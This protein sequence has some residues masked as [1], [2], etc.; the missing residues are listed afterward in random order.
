MNTMKTLIMLALILLVRSVLSQN[1]KIEDLCQFIADDFTPEVFE[2]Q[3]RAD[4]NKAMKAIFSLSNK[5]LVNQAYG[6]NS[7]VYDKIMDTIRQVSDFNP[8]SVYKKVTNLKILPSNT[9]LKAFGNHTNSVVFYCGFTRH[10]MLCEIFKVASPDPKHEYLWKVLIYNSGDGLEY[11]PEYHVGPRKQYSPVVIYEGPPFLINE[12]WVEAAMNFGWYE[13]VIT[14]FYPRLLGAFDRSNATYNAFIDPKRKRPCAISSY[15]A[16]F[17]FKLNV[18]VCKMIF[19]V[20]S[21][22]GL[23]HFASGSFLDLVSKKYLSKYALFFGFPAILLPFYKLIYQI[24]NM[25]YLKI[26]TRPIFLLQCYLTEVARKFLDSIPFLL[27]ERR[28]K[29]ESFNYE[30]LASYTTTLNEIGKFHFLRWNVDLVDTMFRYLVEI[31]NDVFGTKEHVFFRD[32]KLAYDQFQIARK[33]NIFDAVPTHIAD[34]RGIRAFFSGPDW[35]ISNLGPLDKLS[36]NETFYCELPNFEYQDGGYDRQN[37]SEFSSSILHFLT[38]EIAYQPC[39][40]G[41]EIPLISYLDSLTFRV[42]PMV[43]NCTSSDIEK[44]DFLYTFFSKIWRLLDYKNKLFIYQKAL[45]LVE[46]F[47]AYK[48]IY[49]TYLK[50]SLNSDENKFKVINDRIFEKLSPSFSYSD[51]IDLLERIL[52]KS[53]K[54]ISFLDGDIEITSKLVSILF[55]DSKDLPNPDEMGQFFNV[56]MIKDQIGSASDY[57]YDPEHFKRSLYILTVVSN[58]IRIESSNN[59]AIP[60]NFLLDGHYYNLL[61]LLYKILDINYSP[62]VSGATFRLYFGIPTYF[63][64]SLKVKT[65]DYDITEEIASLSSKEK[66]PLGLMGLD[67]KFSSGFSFLNY[68]QK[69]DAFILSEAGMKILYTFLLRPSTYDNDHTKEALPPVIEYFLSRRDKIL[70]EIFINGDDT[71]LFRLLANYQIILN[72]LMS[73]QKTDLDIGDLEH[74][75]VAQYQPIFAFLKLNTLIVGEKFSNLTNSHALYLSVISNFELIKSFFCKEEIQYVLRIYYDNWRFSSSK[76]RCAAQT[77]KGIQNLVNGNFLIDG[78]TRQL[79]RLPSQNHSLWTAMGIDLNRKYKL[80]FT[81]YKRR[82]DGSIFSILKYN[83]MYFILHKNDAFLVKNGQVEAKYIPQDFKLCHSHLD[84][85]IAFNS[86]MVGSDHNIIAFKRC[87]ESWWMW[88]WMWLWSWLWSEEVF[89]LFDKDGFPYG[90]IYGTNTLVLENS[91][92]FVGNLSSPLPCSFHINSFCSFSS[93]SFFDDFSNREPIFNFVFYSYIFMLKSQAQS[94]YFFD[95]YNGPAKDFYVVKEGGE[96]YFA[97]IKGEKFK[98]HPPAEIKENFLVSSNLPLLFVSIGKSFQIIIPVPLSKPGDSYNF[99]FVSATCK[100]DHFNIEGHDREINLAIAYWLVFLKYYDRAMEY[101]S[102]YSSVS[103]QLTELELVILQNILE[104]KYRDVEYLVIEAWANHFLDEHDIFFKGFL[105]ET[106]RVEKITKIANL[107]SVIPFKYKRVL[108]SFLPNINEHKYLWAYSNKLQI[109]SSIGKPAEFRLD[110][111]SLKKD[112][113]DA[114]YELSQNSFLKIE[115]TDWNILKNIHFPS[116]LS[117]LYKLAGSSNDLTDFVDKLN[118]HYVDFTR[119][120]LEMENDKDGYKIISLFYVIFMVFNKL[121]DKENLVTFFAKFKKNTFPYELLDI[122]DRSVKF[123]SSIPYEGSFNITEILPSSPADYENLLNITMQR[124]A[125][126][127]DLFKANVSFTFFSDAASLEEKLK[128]IVSTDEFL[129][130]FPLGALKDPRLLAQILLCGSVEELGAFFTVSAEKVPKLLDLLWSHFITVFYCES[131]LLKKNT[132]CKAWIEKKHSFPQQAEEIPGQKLLVTMQDKVFILIEFFAKYP[133]REQQRTIMSTILHKIVDEESYAVEQ[134]I[135]GA[136]TMRFG[137][138]IAIMARSVLRKLPIFIFSNSILDQNILQLRQWLFDFFGKSVFEFKTERSDYGYSEPYLRYLYYQLTMAHDRGDVFVSSMNSIQCLLN[139]KKELFSQNTDESKETLAWVLRILHFIEH[140]SM[141]VFD[142][143]DASALYSFDTNE[144]AEKDWNLIDV[145]IECF[146]SL[147]DKKIFRSQTGEEITIFEIKEPLTPSTTE[148]FKNTLNKALE[149]MLR[150]TSKEIRALII[151]QLFVSCWEKVRNVGYGASMK[152]S[153]PYPIPYSMANTPREG[154]SFGNQLFMIA[155]SLKFYLENEMKDLSEPPLFFTKA[156]IYSTL[157]ILDYDPVKLMQ[158]TPK[159][160]HLQLFNHLRD[161]IYETNQT[162]DKFLRNVVIKNIKTS[163]DLLASSAQEALLYFSQF[164]EFRKHPSCN[165]EMLKFISNLEIYDKRS[166]VRG[167]QSLKSVAFPAQNCYTKDDHSEIDYYAM[168]TKKSLGICMPK[169]HEF[170]AFMDFIFKLNTTALLDVG[171]VLKDY[172]NSKV[173]KKILDSKKYRCVVY[174]DEK[175]NVIVYQM[176]TGRVGRDLPVEG[177]FSFLET[178][179]GLKNKDIFL[180]LDQAHCFETNVDVNNPSAICVVTFSTLVSA[181][182][183]HQALLTARELLNGISH[184]DPLSHAEDP[185][186]QIKIFV[187][188]ILRYD[189]AMHSTLSEEERETLSSKADLFPKD[190]PADKKA[191]LQTIFTSAHLNQ[192]TRDRRERDLLPWQ[193]FFAKLLK[194]FWSPAYSAGSKIPNW[195]T[196]LNLNDT[197]S[198]DQLKKILFSQTGISKSKILKLFEANEILKKFSPNLDISSIPEVEYSCALDV[199]A[200]L[201]DSQEIHANVKDANVAP[202]KPLSFSR[203]APEIPDLSLGFINYLENI[204]SVSIKSDVTSLRHFYNVHFFIVQNL[205]CVFLDTC[206]FGIRFF[207][208]LSV[209][210]TIIYYGSYVY[211]IQPAFYLMSLIVTRFNSFFIDNFEVEFLNEEGVD[212]GGLSRE[213]ATLMAAQLQV[214]ELSIFNSYKEGFYFRRD[215]KNK[216]YAKFCGAFLGL[217]ISKELTLDCRFSDLFYRILTSDPKNIPLLFKDMELIDTDLHRGFSNSDSNLLNDLENFYK[218][219]DDKKKLDFFK[220]CKRYLIVSPDE[221]IGAHLPR[222]KDGETFTSI[223]LTDDDLNSLRD[224][225][226]HEIY[227]SALKDT[228]ERFLDG[229]HIFI[230]PEELQL[231][232]IEGLRKKVEGEFSEINDKAFEKWKAITVWKYLTNGKTGIEE[233]T[234]KN[235]LKIQKDWFWEIIQK[236]SEK[237]KRDLLQFWTGSRN[238]PK[239]LE[240]NHGGTVN[241]FPS[242][243]TC[244]L[245]LNLP[246]YKDEKVAVDGIETIKGAKEIMKEKILEALKLRSGGTGYLVLSENECV[247]ISSCNHLDNNDGLNISSPSQFRSKEISKSD[248]IEDTVASNMILYLDGNGP[249]HVVVIKHT[250][251][252]GDSKRAFDEYESEIYC[253]DRQTMSIHTVCEDSLVAVPLMI[254][255]VLPTDLFGRVQVVK[256]D[257]MQMH[258][259]PSHL[260]YCLKAP[261]FPKSTQT[262]NALQ[263]QRRSA[264]KCAFG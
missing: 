171:A 256:P 210:S 49:I 127:S 85:K 212:A 259:V 26:L 55:K 150:K 144:P 184:M 188:S 242:S 129:Y 41:K 201:K 56:D 254:D 252:V 35:S 107:I 10:A 207:H 203:S 47:K 191:A 82:A 123:K 53:K 46:I 206:Y 195:N 42:M 232:S 117:F 81:L 75:F 225:L 3:N 220:A 163:R 87:F 197:K 67:P 261:L 1:L 153:V 142:E 66:R 121:P 164:I 104:I 6:I 253:C 193:V 205:I 215:G 172:C 133:L 93:Q 217:A 80:E 24:A 17:T 48:E 246:Y 135:D 32:L 71:E 209:F 52:P 251:E 116:C 185:R 16:Y 30:K 22:S 15:R 96:Q 189:K 143:V 92:K 181:K 54:F 109:G 204:D 258:S 126:S 136:S 76:S 91:S 174:Y 250:P 248:V 264:D 145:L 168:L 175:Q 84:L 230:P 125:L 63:I 74:V 187:S 36:A 79:L 244:L 228:I 95:S 155:I 194:S 19:S 152:S 238:I 108:F 97:V 105:D 58:P 255:L 77:E 148:S 45:I 169:D 245:S 29:I 111:P 69:D 103:L 208:F 50:D 262:V 161:K 234:W 243:S 198:I 7:E 89:L 231:F 138:A 65:H 100:D 214:S 218:D 160:S 73:I 70:S 68:D 94:F 176:D 5:N 120:Y 236:F 249:D 8:S 179:Y 177:Q 130:G 137:P 40:M 165:L 162:F 240:V 186:H 199:E 221:K 28:E 173:A 20:A 178:R 196:I 226:T 101:V 227:Y 124:K 118:S 9:D 222:D 106:N 260:S 202:A 224:E 158:R 39:F 263:S 237:E 233:E 157:K 62:Y 12:A 183:F 31:G 43:K 23:Q 128:S 4:A 44:M 211:E 59:T 134:E 239:T 216:E 235:G 200:V 112:I 98:I 159:L 11:H 139:A 119:F 60:K 132:F 25:L 110:I 146:L 257:N 34:N 180:Y 33:K 241:Y 149:K 167:S 21:L 131:P 122:Y 64:S 147:K 99:T 90:K 141:V 166:F 190:M 78:E 88:L 115:L 170:K 83:S 72:R 37:F 61:D 156:N 18:S 2:G 151:D 13:K 38:N 213:W 229:V 247:S 102:L 14:N 219:G 154:S 114:E 182:Y 86:K 51:E 57:N 223:V 113:Q 27:K 192:L 140:Y